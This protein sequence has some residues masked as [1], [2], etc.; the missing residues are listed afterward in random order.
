L[1]STADKSPGYWD[2]P[3]RAQGAMF[4]SRILAESWERVGVGKWLPENMQQM[5]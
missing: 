1:K 4:R 5:V 3:E 2:R